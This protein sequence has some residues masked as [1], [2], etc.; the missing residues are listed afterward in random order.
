MSIDI[1]F[2]DDD[3]KAAETF[4]QL[5]EAKTNLKTEFTSDPEEALSLLKEY[6]I[7][8]VVLDQEM[9]LKKGT[10]LYKQM[11]NIDNNIKAIMLTGEA[12]ASEAGESLK[13][14]YNCYLEKGN[15]SELPKEVLNLVAL[16]ELHLIA[17]QPSQTR[18]L[19]FTQRK[20]IFL[21]TRIDYFL[22]SFEVIDANYIQPDSWKTVVTI[23]AGEKIRHKETIEVC[24]KIT[25]DKESEAKLKGTLELS[26]DAVVK[27]KSKLESSLSEKYKF[28]ESTEQKKQIEIE[29]EYSLPQEDSDPQKLA[30]KSRHYLIAPVYVK[31]RLFLL[32]KCKESN[33]S[34]IFPLDITKETNRVATKQ[35]D[36]LSDGTK[37]ELTT[38]FINS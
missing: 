24:H 14:G 9:P 13:L 3:K 27:L 11:I 29:K 2:V 34:Q 10:E 22:I 15:I 17:K 23:N 37:T 21:K 26:H 1:L 18:K 5:V 32:L 19:I 12:T 31:Y 33:L 8:V 6:P 16:Y 25:I 36:Y 38:G 4:A 30:V 28:S 35:I 20:G 7:K